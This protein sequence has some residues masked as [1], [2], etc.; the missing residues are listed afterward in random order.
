MSTIAFDLFT[1]ACI[2][3]L[4]I[5]SGFFSE[6]EIK[7]SKILFKNSIRLYF[8]KIFH[9]TLCSTVWI[10]IAYLLFTNQFTLLNFLIVLL[11]G[12]STN[13]LAEIL[14]MTLDAFSSIFEHLRNKFKF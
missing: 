8:G 2:C 11:Y 13:I 4:I 7:L 1:I 3:T 14:H 5:E 12:Y 6:I 9:C 10:S